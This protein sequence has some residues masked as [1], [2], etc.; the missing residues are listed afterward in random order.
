MVLNSVENLRVGQELKRWQEYIRVSPWR[1]R[2][3]TAARCQTPDLLAMLVQPRLT[4]QQRGG[5]RPLWSG[6]VLCHDH[7]LHVY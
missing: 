6:E 2:V 7:A 1:A 5:G 3:G 4:M